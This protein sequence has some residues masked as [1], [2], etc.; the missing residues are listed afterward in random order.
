LASFSDK[1]GFVGPISDDFGQASIGN[2]CWKYRFPLKLPVEFSPLRRMP[3]QLPLNVKLRCAGQAPEKESVKRE[4]GE[5]PAL[6]RSGDGN[7]MLHGASQR[8]VLIE[9]GSGNGVGSPKSEDRPAA[10]TME[11]LAADHGCA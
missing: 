9:M 10:T 3:Q 11:A 2:R 8:T 1:P 6:S 7:E 5:I 4:A